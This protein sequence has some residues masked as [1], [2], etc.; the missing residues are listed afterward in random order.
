MTPVMYLDST[1]KFPIL[2]SLAIIFGIGAMSGVAGTFIG[3]IAT[4]AMTGEW[5]FSSWETYVGSAIGYGVGAIAITYLGPTVGL[6]ISGGLSTFAGMSLEKAAGTNNRS[7]GEIVGWTAGSAAF[8][9]VMG[10][11]FKGLRVSGITAGRGSFQH[12]MRTQFTNMLRHGYNISFKTAAKSFLAMT[13][14]R[15]ITG[16]LFT[17]ARRTA[18]EWWEYLIQGDRE[19]LGW[20]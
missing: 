16:G 3:D 18:I 12:V 10:H 17:S 1:G 13:V 20:V 15:Q 8:S 4:S 5:S 19:G 2:I 6:A 7:W 14:S 11:A 9:A